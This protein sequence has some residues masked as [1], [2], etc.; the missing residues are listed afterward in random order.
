MIQ[1][2]RALCKSVRQ[3]SSSQCVR[4][5]I[6]ICVCVCV[7]VGEPFPDGCRGGVN[8][9]RALD[10]LAKNVGGSLVA[11]CGRGTWNNKNVP[12]LLFSYFTT[13]LSNP[14]F[15]FFL[16]TF[17]SPNRIFACVCV[18]VDAFSDIVLKGHGGGGDCRGVPVW[19][20][21]GGGEEGTRRTH[22]YRPV[23]TRARRRG[24]APRGCRI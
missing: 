23:Y 4:Q 5:V 17:F 3:K 2:R 7:C 22:V 12:V 1:Q 13:L 10:V 20:Q 24:G 8:D 21:R 18:C 14:D 16:K 19:W 15:F 11:H 6:G 9:F